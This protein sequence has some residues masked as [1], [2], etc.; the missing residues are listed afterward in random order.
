MKKKYRM[1]RGGRLA[2]NLVLLCVLVVFIW[3]LLGFSSPTLRGRFRRVAQANWADPLEIQGVLPCDGQ[4]W[5]LAAGQDQV[6]LWQDG[7]DGLEYW[8]RNPNG[9]TLVPVPE[10]RTAQG[11]I[12]VAAADV[13][14]GTV[15]AGLELT[16]GCWYRKNGTSG[17]TFSSRPEQPGD[18]PPLT[19]QWEKTYSAAGELLQD[20]AVLF[21]IAVEEE[22][23]E[24]G[25]PED[26]ILSCAYEWDLYWS[27]PKRRGVDC[28]M[29]AVFYD[30]EGRELERAVLATTEEG[31]GPWTG[32]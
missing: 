6:I 30:A 13:P 24:G 8:P 4:R 11:E 12:W 1:S 27:E 29:E 31:G 20:G 23:D 28:A 25:P 32:G 19:Q 3:G 18:L 9:A 22:P 14:A 10:M 17:W 16:V 7:R 15:S 21:H 26:L 5:V 2:L